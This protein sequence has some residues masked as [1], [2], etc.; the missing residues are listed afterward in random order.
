MKLRSARVRQRVLAP[1]TTSK[2]VKMV[3]AKLELAQQCWWEKREPHCG[4]G[5]SERFGIG[6]WCGRRRASA[7]CKFGLA[8][9]VRAAEQDGSLMSML[10]GARVSVSTTAM[11]MLMMLS[12][13]VMNG[14]EH[15]V[16]VGGGE[17][18]K[19]K[20]PTRKRRRVMVA[21][22]AGAGCRRRAGG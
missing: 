7:R 12:L 22:G 19:G 8:I 6:W 15:E 11:L 13:V 14:G 4:P 18:R 20:R 17:N 10:V 9:G 21:T 16:G 2:D 1:S 5:S 3:R